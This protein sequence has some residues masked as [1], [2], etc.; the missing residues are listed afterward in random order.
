MSIGVGLSKEKKGYNHIG[1]NSIDYSD[2]NSLGYQFNAFNSNQILG[3]LFNM[4]NSNTF[5]N[6]CGGDN[7]NNNNNNNI[8]NNNGTTDNPMSTP[9]KTENKQGGKN[10]SGVKNSPTG[11]S[12]LEHLSAGSNNNNNNNNGIGGT[13]N[14]VPESKLDNIRNFINIIEK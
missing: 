2:A 7:N 4:N 1:N 11:T 5:L 14:P 8:K 13:Q 10:S 12:G 3:T 6:L 9:T